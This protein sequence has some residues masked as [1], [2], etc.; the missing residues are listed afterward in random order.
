MMRTTA[1]NVCES[2]CVAPSDLLLG[3]ADVMYTYIQPFNRSQ[4]IVEKLKA[5]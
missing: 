5:N 2:P 1:T 4:F 3:A